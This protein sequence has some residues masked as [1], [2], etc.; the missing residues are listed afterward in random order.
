MIAHTGVSSLTAL[1]TLGQRLFPGQARRVG[2][3]A[4][5]LT[6]LAGRVWLTG[7]GDIEDRVVSAGER[8][9]LEAADGMVMEALDR[10]EPASVAWR[11]RV[12]VIAHLGLRELFGAAFA[13]LARKAASKASRAH[14]SISRADSMACSGAV[15]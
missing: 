3:G 4:G 10:S 8:I 14:G 2:H 1:D 9:R 7:P 11:P 15:K 12:S 6:V 13:A 5:E